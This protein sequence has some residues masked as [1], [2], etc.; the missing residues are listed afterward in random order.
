MPEKRSARAGGRDALSLVPTNSRG[1]SLLHARLLPGIPRINSSKC[2][3]RNCPCVQLCGVRPNFAANLALRRARYSRPSSPSSR[4][5]R[6]IIRNYECRGEVIRNSCNYGRRRRGS[7]GGEI[8]G[9]SADPWKM[10]SNIDIRI[11]NRN[12]IRKS[13]TLRDTRDATGETGST[14]RKLVRLSCA[15]SQL[16]EV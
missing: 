16:A 12:F 6:R 9:P 10:R 14:N 4:L 15:R 11:F 1:E 13:D 7:L 8:S 3:P 2:P 5:G